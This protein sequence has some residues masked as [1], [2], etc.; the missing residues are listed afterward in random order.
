MRSWVWSTSTI[1]LMPRVSDDDW[2]FSMGWI[3]KER[4]FF[5]VKKKEKKRENIVYFRLF[6]CKRK[7]RW[8]GLY[9]HD[10][11]CS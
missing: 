11:V 4:F 1:R 9:R 7:V 5:F 8:E 6:T 10:E 3:G 2:D